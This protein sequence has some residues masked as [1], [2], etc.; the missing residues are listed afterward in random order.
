M[1]G[2]QTVSPDPSFEIDLAEH[3]RNQYSQAQLIELYSRFA[4]SEANFDKLMRR[5]FWRSLTASFGQ[6]VQIESAVGFKHL[7][8][9]Q[10]GDRVFIGSQSYLQGRFDGRCSIG[11]RVWIGPQSYFDARDLVIEA[12]VGLGPGT[13]ILGSTHTA[14]PLDIPIIQTDLDIKPVRI[15]AGADIGMNA[16]ILPGVT[17]GQGSMVGA[18][19]VVTKDVPPYAIVVGVPAQ[20]LR[21]REESHSSES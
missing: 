10:I 11:D 8:T 5:V 18:G 20:F 9:F 4:S 15:E 12:D 1:H 16:V 3:L 21:W 2:R 6:G 13:K 19:A 7:E 17:I 14:Q